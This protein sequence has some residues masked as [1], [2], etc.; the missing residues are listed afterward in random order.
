MPYHYL[1]AKKSPM[2]RRLTQAE[3]AARPRVNVRVE[4]EDAAPE[5]L[6]FTKAFRI[7]REEACEL[8]ID[9]GYVSRV[10]AEVVFEDGAWWVRDLGSTNGL[11]FDDEKV[12][13]MR[14]QDRTTI[15]L[16]QNA[17]FLHFS[18]EAADAVPEDAAAPPK[19][20]RLR[21][22]LRATFRPQTERPAPL[23]PDAP[24]ERASPG[25]PHADPSLS[26]IIEHYLEADTGQPAGEYTM[27][28]RRAYSTVKEKQKRKYTWIIVGVLAL[29]VVVFGFWLYER[30]ERNKLR[31]AVAEM[32]YVLRQSD[33]DIV[34]VITAR[35]DSVDASLQEEL[36]RIRARRDEEAA[37]YD[38]LV[39]ELGLYRRLNEEEQLIYK[40]ARVFNESQADIP[41]G[42][43]REV[44]ATIRTQWLT[45]GG[46]Q[47][48]KLAIETAQNNNY[49]PHIVETFESHGLPSQFFYLALQ[50]S[51]YDV[52]AL[53]YYDHPVFGRAKGMWQF[54]PE[55]ARRYKLFV[56][57]RKENVKEV[58]PGDE[59]HDFEK[60]TEA[61]ADYLQEI[62][63][64]LAQASG[65]LA[66]ASY[67][68]GE[69]RV[70]PR[71]NELPGLEG[72]DEGAL[73]ET[74]R[75]RSYWN[76]LREYE[77]QM[78]KQTK[79]Y[80]LKIFAAAVIGENPR[81]Y[82]FDFDN[83]LKPRQEALRTPSD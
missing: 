18:L 51:K 59:R 63:I 50:E 60:S 30:N 64:T 1:T 22:G 27:M 54:I 71:L 79:D 38:G 62:Y 24:P 16:G 8:Q 23:A 9:S 45:P 66:M 25:S 36:D 76:F 68:W 52:N 6:A 4:Q 78:P 57:E 77:A 10:H 40:T 28:I 21:A 11:Y 2:S 32:S 14:L 49:I 83:P 41:A 58:V 13:H 73:P 69:G 81:F 15:Q 34:K 44:K 47:T 42:F 43:V 80:V 67:N 26:H 82:D 75:A 37:R 33:L 7:G 65:L 70:V 61:A 20:A 3:Q 12:S 55:T 31:R 17:P 39:F 74:P 56:P 53:G 29:S 5:V 35:G 72:V 19:R 46:R 48:Y